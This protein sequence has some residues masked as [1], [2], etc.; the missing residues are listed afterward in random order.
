MRA[1]IRTAIAGLTTTAIV[2]GPTS[3]AT[4]APA[5]APVELVFLNALAP[6]EPLFEVPRLAVGVVSGP[7]RAAMVDTG[8]TGVL[9]SATAIPDFDRLQQLGSGTLPAFQRN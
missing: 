8:S 7:R 9:L 4:P 3:A 6:G 1:T 2:I 5:P